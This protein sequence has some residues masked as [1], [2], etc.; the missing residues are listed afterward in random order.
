M[1]NKINFRKPET[2]DIDI[3]IINFEKVELVNGGYYGAY[4]DIK[5][6][7]SNKVTK[8]E[9]E[10]TMKNIKVFA[11][12]DESIFEY[13]DEHADDDEISEEDYE[14]YSKELW[15]ELYDEKITEY[16]NMLLEDGYFAECETEI[17]DEET[18]EETKKEIIKYYTNDYYTF[19]G[20]TFIETVSE[21]YLKEH[22]EEVYDINHEDFAYKISYEID[23]NTV[24]VYTGYGEYDVKMNRN[25]SGENGMTD[26]MSYNCENVYL[27]Y[28]A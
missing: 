16:Y 19:D 11:F 21:K 23:S 27:E 13:Y 10:M 24:E 26:E 25:K 9:I 7:V 1:E 3:E 14:E 6:K 20:E 4:A 12:T 28:A 5:M 8:E 18:L 22:T 15:N 2:S 17:L